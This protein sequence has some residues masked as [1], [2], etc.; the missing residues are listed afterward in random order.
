MSV[1]W[2]WKHKMGEICVEQSHSIPSAND[3]NTKDVMK[4]KVNLYHANCLFAAIYEYVDPEQLDDKGKPKRLYQFYGFFADMDH[5]S[6]C[7]GLKPMEC[8][9][10]KQYI[11]L[12][13]GKNSIDHWTKIRLNT[14][15]KENLKIATAFTKAK[16]KVELYYQEPKE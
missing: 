5:L 15:Y 6:R 9:G 2:S 14:Y 16:F 10:E 13:D 1:N 7:I 3:I 12:Y 11:N 8:N 4:F